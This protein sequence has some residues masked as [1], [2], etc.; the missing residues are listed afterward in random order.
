M[1]KIIKALNSFGII[2]LFI[3]TFVA[4]EKD[5][6][7]LKSDVLGEDKVNFITRD[8]TFGA[9]AYNKKLDSLQVNGFASNLLGVY[10][11]PAYGQ[12]IANIVTQVTPQSLNPVF[13]ENPVIDSVVLTIPYFS[14]IIEN[15]D[16]GNPIYKLD[17]LYGNA[18]KKIK[19]SVFQN[20]Y[21]LRDFDPHADLG[22]S[23]NYYSNAYNQSI[24]T[25]S[26]VVDFDNHIVAT[27][28]ED[29]EFVPSNDPIITTVGSGDDEEKTRSAPAY[30]VTFTSPEKLAYWTNTILNK[31]DDPVLSNLDN[32]RNYFRGLYFKVEPL[33]GDGTI[34][35]LNLGANTA[36]ITIYFTAD[37]DDGDSRVQKTYVLNFS[38]TRV[39]TFLNDYN[40]VTIPNANKS[41]GDEKL[42]L[43]GTSG[44][45]AVVDIFGN[46]Q[47]LQAFLDTFRIPDGYGGYE[48]DSNGDYILKRLIN[49]AHLAL[50][51]DELLDNSTDINGDA[52]HK[53]DRIYAY[54]IKNNTPTVDYQL[55]QIVNTQDPVNSKVVSLSQRDT[56]T[57]KY[58]IRLTSHLNNI[59]LRDSTNTK[60]GLV[61]SNNVNYTNNAQIL[62]SD[63]EVTA[64][65][66]ATILSPRG[67][68]LY[69]SNSSRDDKKMRFR[70][71][72]TEPN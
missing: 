54:D 64:V 50:Y 2:A 46:D 40:R 31:E 37:D 69:G 56:I 33:N 7:T 14:Q 28:H 43:K 30:R 44:A 6:I 1:K 62:N 17:S 71:F 52:F 16:D 38:G 5:F 20:N 39:N 15:D 42:Y 8:T 66:A 13:D 65:P 72:F 22:S 58:K 12:T 55:D 25:G 47:N 32:F 70:V 60:I 19:L 27:I 34:T 41:L 48:R 59:L 51:E 4:C 21:F 49:E 26:S 18:S 24:L 3:S 63:D 57:G 53:Y 35:L 10:N 45:M 61:I 23:Q 36:N 29:S 67:T 68:V 11:D 9:I